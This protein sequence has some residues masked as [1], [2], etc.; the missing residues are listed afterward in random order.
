M[1][2]NKE[3]VSLYITRHSKGE[4]H[5][6]LRSNIEDELTV[7]EREACRHICLTH[8]IEQTSYSTRFCVR[9]NR[10]M[11]GAIFLRSRKNKSPVST[12]AFPC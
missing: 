9:T 10:A 11:E 2:G 8:T 12:A 4:Y 5:A 6:M 7:E 3:L 1:A